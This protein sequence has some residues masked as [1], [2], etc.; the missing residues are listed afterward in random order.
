MPIETKKHTPIVY[1]IYHYL[2]KNCVGEENAI[3]ARD[4]AARF[5]LKDTRELR[6][7]ISIIRKSGELRKDIGSSQKGYYVC[8]NKEEAQKAN[9]TFWSAAVS[10]LEVAKAQEKKAGLDGQYILA[11]GDYYKEIYEAFGE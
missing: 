11:L 6:D 1:D 8:A 9:Q 10:Y 3:T 2:E 7:Y 5:G 4:L